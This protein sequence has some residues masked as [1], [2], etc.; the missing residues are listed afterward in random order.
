MPKEHR[1]RSLVDKAMYSHLGNRSL[2]AT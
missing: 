1:P 2:N